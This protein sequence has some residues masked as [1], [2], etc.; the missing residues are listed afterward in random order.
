MA[1]QIRY[2]TIIFQDSTFDE[3]KKLQKRLTCMDKKN[4][5]LS[6]VINLLLKFYFEDKKDAIY[7][8][9]FPFLQDYFIM[10]NSFLNDFV[11]DVFV[12]HMPVDKNLELGI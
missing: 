11:T 9:K 8:H 5:N 3:I 7:A 6:N 1:K 10:N 12:S 4:W 2:Y